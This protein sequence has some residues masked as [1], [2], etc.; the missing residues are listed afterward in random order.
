[1]RSTTLI[2]ALAAVVLFATGF[3]NAQN[4]YVGV[5]KC[6]MCHDKMAKGNAY[7]TWEKS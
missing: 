2:L 1:M 6:S 5:K 4:K 7:A 3:S